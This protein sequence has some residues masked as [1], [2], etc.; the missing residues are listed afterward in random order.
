MRVRTISANNFKSLVD[1]RLDLGKFTCLIGLNSAGKSTVLQFIDFLAQQVRGDIDGWLSERNWRSKDMKSQ[2]T[3]KNNIDFSVCLAHDSGEQATWEASFN[4]VQLHCTHERIVIGKAYL[5]VSGGAVHVGE[6]WPSPPASSS[7]TSSSQ[8]VT[9]TYQGSILSQLKESTLPA[10]LVDFRRFFLNVKSLDLLS[11]E[12][13]RQRTRESGGSLGLGGQRLSAFLHELGTQERRQM[14]RRL[15]SVYPRLEDLHTRALR[16]GWKQLEITEAYQG[17]KSGLF[18]LMTTEARHIADGMLRLIAILAETETDHRFL[19][20]DEIENGIN[21]ELVEFVLDALVS[22]PQQVLV[23]THSPMILNYLEDDV[24]REG[25]MYLHKTREGYTR[26]TP[27]FQIPSVAEKLTVMG[28]GEA[29]ADTDLT[30][31]CDEIHRV[32]GGH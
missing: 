15:K 27:F 26:A 6:R 2:L 12:H 8:E 18:S 11:P 32:V 19:L 7:G 28:P 23:T 3:K 24:A 21:P 14:L 9:F 10:P 1:F 5:N 20:F 16:S 30:A 29:F 25:V 17:A 22:A 4:P 13:L 31:L